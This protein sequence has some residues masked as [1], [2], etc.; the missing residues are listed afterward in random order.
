M[1]VR[2]GFVQAIE[3]RQ[4]HGL[5][6]GEPLFGAVPQIADGVLTCQADE[7]APMPCRRARRRVARPP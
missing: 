4:R 5:D 7:T 6:D 1:A 2:I 3:L